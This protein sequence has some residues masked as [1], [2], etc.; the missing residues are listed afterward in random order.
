MDAV[1]IMF[2]FVGIVWVIAW[3]LRNDNVS[4][5]GEQRGMFS[6]PDYADDEWAKKRKKEKTPPL[7]Y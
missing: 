4:S 3:S 6:M 5:I 1:F 7:V 2:F